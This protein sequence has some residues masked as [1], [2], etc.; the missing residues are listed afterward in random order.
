LEIGGVGLDSP[1]NSNGGIE[2]RIRGVV[3]NPEEIRKAF[4]GWDGDDFE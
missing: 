4:D 2:I 1:P 3:E